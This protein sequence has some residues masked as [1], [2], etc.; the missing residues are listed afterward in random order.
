[1]RSISPYLFASAWLQALQMLAWWPAD[2]FAESGFL[3]LQHERLATAEVRP[4]SR[5]SVLE[6]DAP[7]LASYIATGQLPGAVV[8]ELEAFGSSAASETETSRTGLLEVDTD[9]NHDD[10]VAKMHNSTL[11]AMQIYEERLDTVKRQ[12][13][14]ARK[15]IEEQEYNLNLNFKPIQQILTKLIEHATVTASK[16]EVETLRE[17]LSR[18]HFQQLA[19]LDRSASHLQSQIDENAKLAEKF[20]VQAQNFTKVAKVAKRK[21]A[22]ESSEIKEQRKK[23]KKILDNWEQ[24]W[25]VALNRSEA[26]QIACYKEEEKRTRR[27]LENQ[28]K[29]LVDEVLLRAEGE[30]G[31]SGNHSVVAPNIS[32]P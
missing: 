13:E 1:M 26:L 19:A 29:A 14:N 27:E 18:V 8:H 9:A 21:F 2:V 17:R 16:A 25:K 12:A 3:S 6:L 31:L 30:F 22:D 28:K 4:H 7:D 32:H 10:A 24:E 15:A 20:K 5:G 11:S 23:E